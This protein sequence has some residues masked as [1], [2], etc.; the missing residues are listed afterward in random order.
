M[1]N[2]SKQLKPPSSSTLKPTPNYL[3]VLTPQPV[4]DIFLQNKKPLKDI[5]PARS[6]SS[7]SHYKDDNRSS[8]STSNTLSSSSSSSYPINSKSSNTSLVY[9]SNSSLSSGGGSLKK[10]SKEICD[11]KIEEIKT[12]V[13]NYRLKNALNHRDGTNNMETLSKELDY[14]LS[15]SSYTNISPNNK[16]LSYLKK[17]TTQES[18]IDNI[19]NSGIKNTMK[20]TTLNELSSINNPNSTISTEKNNKVKT[21]TNDLV[22]SLIDQYI[23]I[24]FFF[25]T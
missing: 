7:L 24:Y 12:R 16:Y 5:L 15:S 1:L 25:F 11:L 3:E 6:K 10:L 4:D 21:E 18:N 20:D 8:F 23:Y 2:H 13:S 14:D 9:S 19:K 22:K 17:T